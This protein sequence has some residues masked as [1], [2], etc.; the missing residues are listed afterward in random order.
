MCMPMMQCKK[1]QNESK[2][3]LNES[4]IGK[5]KWTDVLKLDSFQLC[6]HV[7]AMRRPSKPHP[8]CMNLGFMKRLD[9]GEQVWCSTLFHLEL[10]TWR[11]LR[12]KFGNFNILKFFSKC[13]AIYLNI[14]PCLTFY[15]SFKW[16]KCIHQSCSSL[17][18]I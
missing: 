2:Q 12:W 4:F 16:G 9:Q 13:Q 17:K 8:K 14:P 7:K 18:E 15:G 1:V 5:A 10:G 6:S 3:S 11:I